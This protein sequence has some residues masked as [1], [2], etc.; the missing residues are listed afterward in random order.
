[1]SRKSRKSITADILQFPIH[2]IRRAGLYVRLSNLNAGKT[3]DDSIETQTEYLKQSLASHPDIILEDIYA[4]NGF[5]GR[6][7]ERPQF[8]RLLSDIRVKRIDCVVVKDFSRLGRNFVETGYY[9]EKLF[10]FLD[11]RF[12]SIN[13]SYDSDDLNSRGSLSVP[14]KD[15]LN[16]YYSKDISRKVKGSFEVKRQNGENIHIIPYGYKKDSFNP[17]KL[18]IDEETA[19]IVRIIF[20]TYAEGKSIGE[21]TKTLNEMN[22]ILPYWRRKQ[23]GLA[24]ASHKV[25]RTHWITADVVQIL[26]NP[27]YTGDMVYNRLS[28][29]DGYKKTPRVNPKSEWQIVKD[30]HPAIISRELYEQVELRMTEYHNLWNI[31]KEERAQRK[32]GSPNAYLG[33]L[34]CAH[35]GNKLSVRKQQFGNGM[36]YQHFNCVNPLCDKGVTI[37]ERLLRIRI[38]DDIRKKDPT[39]DASVIEADTLAIQKQISDCKNEKRYLYEQM[40]AGKIDKDEYIAEKELLNETERQL[41]Q[42]ITKNV[43]HKDTL[44]EGDRFSSEL[45]KR[46]VD[47]IDV[48]SENEIRITYKSEVIK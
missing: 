25:S 15:M 24:R 46:C 47:R 6:N 45:L 17:G 33:I 35:C 5:T 38:M 34:F 28:Y 40:I 41:E 37:A 14:I 22:V 8:E 13:D 18:A 12:I 26:D 11:I 42:Q 10:P 39:S 36:I 1:M 4:D 44:P 27:V 32:E 3:D 30:A 31:R 43:S 23:L 16:D 21:I 48:V 7:F 20:E 19:D 9:I 29:P 2:H